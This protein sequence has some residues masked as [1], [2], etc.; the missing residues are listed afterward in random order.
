MIVTAPMPFIE[1]L[2]AADVKSFLPTTGK[3][4][5]LR[6]LDAGIRRDA[7][8]SATVAIVEPLQKVADGVNAL[9]TGQADQ[10]TV[11]LG[12]KQ[13]WEA[14]GYVPDPEKAGGL[15]DLSSTRRLNLLIETQ[16]DMARG[17]G[18]YEQGMQADVLDEFPAQE[19]YNTREG[20]EHR[21]DWAKRWAEQ[22]GEFFGSRMIAL[23]T[24]GIWQRLADNYDDGLGNP[25]PP[26]A[27]G[28]F[29]DVRDIGR[30][31]TEQLGL[32]DKDTELF[33][34]PM[35]FGRQ[36]ER[37]PEVREEWLR[38]AI[39]DGGVGEFRDG[40]LTFPETEGGNP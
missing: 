16:V 20:G 8:W 37:G 1:A 22:G 29:W 3:T 39:E 40:V 38:S 23:K 2:D 18:N 4:A 5:D 9:L 32:I 30:D 25:Y 34:Q 27:F 13:M 15:E 14:L 21:R 36:L 12:L 19:L 11:R 31:E 35:N 6:R 28:S 33:P 7:L 17:A 26:F 24:D 10:A